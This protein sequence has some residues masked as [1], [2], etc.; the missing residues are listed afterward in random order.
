MT[1]MIIFHEVK[2]GDQWAEAWR[3]GKGSRH[4]MFGKH[5][6]KARTFRDPKNPESTGVILEVPDMAKC[7]AFLESD[8]AKK[9]M[10][11]DGLKV[12]TV[13]AL[14]EFTP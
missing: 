4:E 14:V 2:S 10:A 12:D 5:G 1:T 8:E 9:A 3:K 13:R 6:I 7:Q 11:E